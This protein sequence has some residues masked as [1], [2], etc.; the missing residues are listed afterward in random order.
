[1]IG[2]QQPRFGQRAGQQPYRLI[3]HARFRAGWHFLE[4]RCRSGELEGERA[5]LAQL[6][7]RFADAT[8]ETREAMLKP[9][10]EPKKRAR[11]RSRGRRRRADG[12]A[13]MPPNPDA[14]PE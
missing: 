8:S 7:D 5:Q 1:A 4:L 12:E 6:W 10:T 2:S 3:E 9:D 11:T 13:V 14:L